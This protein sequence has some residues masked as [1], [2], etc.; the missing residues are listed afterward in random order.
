MTLDATLELSVEQLVDAL[1]KKLF[2]EC[3]RVQAAMP[4][5][6]RALAATLA[7]E[8]RSCVP[9]RNLGD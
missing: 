9:R 3:A 7:T 2:M 5:R 8:V 1:N 6:S 4:P